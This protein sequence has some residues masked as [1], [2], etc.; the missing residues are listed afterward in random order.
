M[1]VNFEIRIILRDD[2]F[3]FREFSFTASTVK[4][5]KF[6]GVNFSG[7]YG[8]VIFSRYFKL[9]IIIGVD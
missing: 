4:G 6:L 9:R 8:F 2:L 5:T 7:V 3:H 1:E